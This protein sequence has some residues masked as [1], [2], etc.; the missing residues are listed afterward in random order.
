MLP[1]L[2]VRALNILIIIFVNFFS[3]SSNIPVMYESE[4][5]S[6]AC[7]VSSNCVFAF[8]F[9]LHV[10]LSLSTPPDT[11]CRGKRAA[12]RC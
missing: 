9:Y 8:W 2:S 12:V 6:D 11:I 1:T 5:G 10:H 7:S 4:S 3:D